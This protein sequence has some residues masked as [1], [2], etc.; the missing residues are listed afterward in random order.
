MIEKCIISGLSHLGKL[1]K[2][3]H[4]IHNFNIPYYAQ[5]DAIIK[6]RLLYHGSVNEP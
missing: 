6:M 4:S 1:G 2:S 3:E 5:D